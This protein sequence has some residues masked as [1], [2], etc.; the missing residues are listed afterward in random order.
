[1]FKAIRLIR[2]KQV[3]KTKYIFLL[4]ISVI[5]GASL[6]Y[7]GLSLPKQGYTFTG[8][9]IEPP[10]EA[11]DFSLLDQ[12]GQPFT[13]SEQRGKVVLLFFGY[14]N[15][16]DVCPATLVKYRRITTLLGDQASQVRFVMV[17]ADPERDTA[18]Q[19][20]NYLG[21]FN[22]DFIGLRGPEEILRVIYGSYYVAVEK[23]K[24]EADDQ[25]PGYLVAHTSRVFLIDPEGNLHLTYPAE[26]GPEAMAQDIVYL[27]KI[28]SK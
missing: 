25:T 11:K 10:I 19:L 3:M 6:G 1:M 27:L 5:V 23:E 22:P 28:S 4:I 26:I 14:T 16:P 24:K 8:S 7:F 9:L 17:T 21:G 20:D 12:H 13:L 15:C 2:E 18:A